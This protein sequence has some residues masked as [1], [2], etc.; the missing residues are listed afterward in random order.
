MARVPDHADIAYASGTHTE[1]MVR[2]RVTLVL[3]LVVHLHIWDLFRK[4]EPIGFRIEV[5][6]ED[7]MVLMD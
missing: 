5:T 7:I 2:Q 4:Q 6:S 3:A 1:V